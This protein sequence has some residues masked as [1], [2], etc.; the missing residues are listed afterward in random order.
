VTENTGRGGGITRRDFL[1]ASTGLATFP[2]LFPAQ[3]LQGTDPGIK[4]LAEL[5]SESELEE[6]SRSAMAREID[7]Y[8][9]HGYS[10]AEA[11]LL[12]TLRFLKRDEQLVWAAGAFGGGLGKKD[13]CG[14]LTGGMMALG[15][16]MGITGSNRTAAKKKLFGLRDEFWNWWSS[17]YPLRCGEIVKNDADRGKCRRMAPIVSRKLEELLKTAAS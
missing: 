15:F 8:F 3:S 2:V 16:A 6:L 13:L 7:N 1:I 9:G 4:P 10:C 11:M 14:F 12:V 17:H 5:F